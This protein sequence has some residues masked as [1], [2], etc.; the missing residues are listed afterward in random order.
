MYFEYKNYEC[1]SSN[2]AGKGWRC[3][4]CENC[5]DF[6]RFQW[7]RK[8]ARAKFDM[9]VVFTYKPIRIN[10][11]EK[12]LPYHVKRRLYIIGLEKIRKFREAT[13][14]IFDK[15]WEY[16]AVMD[17]GRSKKKTHWTMH[18]HVLIRGLDESDFN[19]LTKV[20]RNQFYGGETKIV[21]SFCHKSLM[22][23]KNHY[24]NTCNYFAKKRFQ[25]HLGDWKRDY[26]SSKY[27][28]SQQKNASERMNANHKKALSHVISVFKKL[29]K[30]GESRP[31]TMS[32]IAHEAGYK[33]SRKLKGK[34]G[35]V[36]ELVEM[37]LISRRKAE[38]DHKRYVYTLYPHSD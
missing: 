32:Q 29:L 36:Q 23:D 2:K 8:I 5:K 33:D 4:K 13:I 16:V 31:L 20:W 37:R 25:I 19:N 35:Y 18:A 24:L 6:K 15:Q 1:S 38:N 14:K 9:H 10:E 28:F 7:G 21:K 22:D 3:W 34:S 12:H 30:E 26:A 27:F 17:I 11:G